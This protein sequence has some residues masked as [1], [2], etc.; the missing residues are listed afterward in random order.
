VIDPA[1]GLDAAGASPSHPA[2]EVDPRGEEAAPQDRIGR[3][4][5]VIT[6][7]NLVSRLTGFARVVAVSA[8]LGIT[9]LGDTYQSANEVSNIMFEL[10]AGGILYAVLVPTFVALLDKGRRRQAADLA[11]ALLGRMLIVLVVL[12]VIAG[13]AGPWIMRLFTIGAG[14]A[15]IRS[16]QIEVGSFLLWFFLP[17]LL[18]YAVGAVATALL[19]AD[20]RFVAAAVAPVFNNVVVMVTMGLFALTA[21]TRVADTLHLT[22]GQKLVLGAGT[23]AGVLLMVLVPVLAARRA[24]L[25]GRPGLRTG[26]PDGLASLAR[27]G[28]W[29]AGHVGLNEVLIFVT[30]V[31]ASRVGGGQA[32]FQVAFTFFLLPHAILGNPIF[33]ALF[34]RLSTHAA[35]DDRDQFCRDLA[36]GLRTTIVMILPAGGLLAVLALPGLTVLRGFGQF[37][38]RGV[39]LVAEVLAAYSFGLLG[40]TA[41]FL[42]TRASYALDDARTPT[43]VN[44]GVTVGAIVGMAAAS[45]LVTGN[46]KVVVLGLVHAVAVSGGSLVLLSRLHRRLGRPIP[47][48]AA[49]LRAGAATAVACAVAWAASTALG[50]PSRSGALLAV[51]VAAGTAL[52]AYGVALTAL[53][54]PE[55]AAVRAK[56]SGRF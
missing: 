44:L 36:F 39:V 8:A 40:Y 9:R 21:D 17:Q 48:V 6:F 52:L 13:F 19:Q 33:T 46:A 50:W 55:L 56:V 31:L 32:A 3:A 49:L 25:A 22:T 38:A 26:A 24:G 23:S 35:R 30:Y 43:M 45:S 15:D 34:P 16:R 2:P 11:G 14:S 27:K 10:L 54:A 29:G 20:R 1:A 53:R 42:L 37:D 41:F 28:V 7:W 5:A 47:F 51:T 18:L 12:V 4:T